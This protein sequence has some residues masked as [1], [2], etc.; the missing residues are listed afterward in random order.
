MKFVWDENKRIINYQKHRVDFR[1]ANRLWYSPMVIVVDQRQCYGK[2]RY[3]GL[4]LLNQRVMVVVYTQRHQS[5]RII[6]F[7]KAN[8]REVTVYEKKVTKQI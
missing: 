4:G 5:I 6:S 1:N 7:R 3:I 2:K 8:K